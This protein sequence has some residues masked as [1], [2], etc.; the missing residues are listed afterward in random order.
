VIYLD[1]NATTP[2]A[3]EVLEAMM[4][5]LTNEWGN[6]SSAYR[7]GSKLKLAMDNARDQISGLAGCAPGDVFF[8]SCATESN[9]AALR[10]ALALN[11]GKRHIVTSQIEHSSVLNFCKELENTGFSVTYLPVDQQGMIST[12]DLKGAISDQTAVVSI[13]WAN[14]ETGVLFPIEEIAAICSEFRVLFHCD[15]VQAPVKIPIDLSAC[16]IDYVTLSAHKIFGPKAC[17]ALISGKQH[18]PKPLLFGGHQEGGWR[19]GTEN[20]AGIVGFGKAAELA[21]KNLS[22]WSIRSQQLRNQLE[23]RILAEISGT[24]LNGSMERRLPNTSN[25]GFP[26]LNSDAL[27]GLLDTLGVCVSSGSACLSN[28]ISPSHVVFSMTGSHEKATKS[29]R[30]STSHLNTNLEIDQAVEAVKQAIATLPS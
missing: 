29:I 25:I 6:P 8:T 12:S 14:N 1:H 17:G 28:S 19:G 9:N 18:L 5:F 20:V 10:A 30:F 13:M 27:V 4:P 24:W 7:F 15:A 2:I 26:T 22:S 16:A 23:T 21:A 11:P 3:Q